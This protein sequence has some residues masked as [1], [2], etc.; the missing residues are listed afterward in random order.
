MSSPTVASSRSILTAVIGTAAATLLISAA[1]FWVCRKFSSSRRTWRRG[2]AKSTSF[3][4]EDAD[5]NDK[6]D[7]LAM[8]VKGLVVDEAGP[9]VIYVRKLDDGRPPARSS[10]P[11]VIFNPSYGREEEKR[12]DVQVD[13]GRT[14]RDGESWPIL[15]HGHER[16]SS[17]EKTV[18]VSVPDKRSSVIPTKPTSEICLQRIALNMVPQIPIMTQPSQPPTPPPYPPPPPPPPPLKS[19]RPGGTSHLR[20][21]PLPPPQLP[22]KP[23]RPSRRA[24]HPLSNTPHPPSAAGLTVS[25]IKP[26]TGLRG[27]GSTRTGTSDSID[28]GSS[29]DVKGPV[30]LKPLHWDKVVA[31][32]DHSVVWNEIVDG[33]LRFD[34]E[35]MESLFGYKNDKPKSREDAMPMISSKLSRFSSVPPA[36][37]FILDPRKSQ[38]TAIVLKSLAMSRKEIIEALVDGN[39]LGTDV[40]EKLN[41]IAPSKE[42]EAK[43]L[44]FDGNQARLADAEY[45]L[46]HLLKA[47]PTAFTRLSAMLF[48]VNYESEISQL[49]DSLRVLEL[50]CRELRTRGLF[51]KL[52]EAV[53]KAGNRMNAG[54]ARG[55]AQA[56]DLSALRKLSD[57]KST[58]GKTTLLHFIVEQV[59]RSEGRSR[60]NKN[61]HAFAGSAGQGNSS[62]HLQLGLQELENLN[63]D[64]SN[65]KKAATT[66]YDGL[67]GTFGILS[68]CVADIRRLITSCDHDKE[69][70][71]EKEMREFLRSCDEELEAVKEEQ[72]KVMELVNRTADYYLVGASKDKAAHPLQL[73]VLVKD[74]LDMVDKVRADIS[75]KLQKESSTGAATTGGQS[76]PPKGPLKFPNLPHNFV[77]EFRRSPMSSDSEGDFQ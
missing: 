4:R 54:T 49:R 68:R 70:R 66:D 51:F 60:L 73:F 20:A 31:N 55:N 28:D 30:K 74:F 1:L 23:A 39:G 18:S 14:T 6:L 17:M 48:R 56:F 72:R 40:L 46:Y 26:P 58:N 37:I 13:H 41:T 59:T 32:A 35:L 62:E 2:G 22:N 21:I 38:N 5:P 11:K 36:K 57:I 65:V 42:E 64:L 53:L 27:G 71:F 50:G 43:I 63:R 47:V 9:D 29:R 52:L 10:F 3:R 33:S 75:Q 67:Q 25:S 8:H 24:N 76:P 44:S 61:P 34:D 16:S 19:P 15:P 45:F 69:R 77:M 12:V 7:M